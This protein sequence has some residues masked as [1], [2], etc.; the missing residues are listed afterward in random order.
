MN[1]FQ[2]VATADATKLDA[3]SARAFDPR[4]G[5]GWSAGQ[6]AGTLALS[7]SWARLADGPAGPVGFTLCR[8]AADEAEL[9]LVGV[10]PAWRQRGIAAMLVT[11]AKNEASRQ[12]A[13]SM[14][15]EVRDGNVA[16]R[17]LYERAGFEIVGRRRDYYGGGFGERFDALTMRIMLAAASL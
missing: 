2:L 10:D 8:R 7:G 3:I 5:E 9:L 4:F 16:A 15:L 12:G 1:G 14:F 13:K 6:L 17:L 11:A